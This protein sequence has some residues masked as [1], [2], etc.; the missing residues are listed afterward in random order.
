[1]IQQAAKVAG[2]VAVRVGLWLGT[3]YLMGVGY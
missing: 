1:M 2:Q 3:G